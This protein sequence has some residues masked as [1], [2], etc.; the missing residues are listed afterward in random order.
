M[1]FRFDLQGRGE[2][3][4][5]KTRAS[6]K[7]APGLEC[8]ED[9][10]CILNRS[11]II[12]GPLSSDLTLY[13]SLSASCFHT[14]HFDN[15]IVGWKPTCEIDG[16]YS[17][18]QCRGDK[19]TGRFVLSFPIENCATRKTFPPSDVSVLPRQASDSLGGIGGVMPMK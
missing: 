10:Y 17:A 19:L 11:E 14:M 13:L 2:S 4:C 7:C 12:C 9:F 8:D 3:G 6:R 5:S 18:K 1:I 16:T 15:E